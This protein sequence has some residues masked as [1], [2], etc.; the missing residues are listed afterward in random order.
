MPCE[1]RPSLSHRCCTAL[2]CSSLAVAVAVAPTQA[3]ASEPMLGGAIMATGMSPT[4]ARLRTIM[5]LQDPDAPAAVTGDPAGD[6]P[7][8]AAPVAQGPAPVGPAPAPIAPAPAGPPPSKGLGMMIA[9]AAITGAYALP[10][11][12]Y[13][14]YVTI[15][16]KR[17]D[18][19]V[20]GMGVVEAGGNILGGTLIVLGVLGLGVGVPLLGVGGYRFSKYQKWKR[21]EVSLRPSM[22]R[23][24]HGTYTSGFTLRF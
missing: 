11:I 17:A 4:A 12:G 13:G 22:N 23:T 7:P 5:S 16:F 19:D 1:T 8:D 20:N 6:A 18:D 15:I 21:G 14:A 3:H 2:V 10:L 24:M 9:G